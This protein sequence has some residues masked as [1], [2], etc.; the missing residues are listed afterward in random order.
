MAVGHTGSSFLVLSGEGSILPLDAPVQVGDFL[1]VWNP[2]VCHQGCS[3]ALPIKDLPVAQVKE[4]VS[5]ALSAGLRKQILSSQGPVLADD[6]I[7]HAPASIAGLCQNVLV[8]EPFQLLQCL[9]ADDPNPLRPYGALVTKGATVISALPLKGHWVTFA[10]DMYFARL[11]AW[12]SCPVG[13]LDLEVSEVHRLWARVFG[14][15]ASCFC[16]RQAPGSRF[17][18]PLCTR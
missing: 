9:Q 3:F 2:Q 7:C 15:T 11:E 6:Q 14:F 1:Y 5:L 10:W 18:W 13:I 8:L 4:L 17:V 16:F 12:D